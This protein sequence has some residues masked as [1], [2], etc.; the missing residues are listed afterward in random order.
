MFPYKL[1]Y[2]KNNHLLI[3]VEKKEYCAI[4]ELNLD[5]E[6]VLLFNLRLKL[7]LKKLKSRWIRPYIINQVTPHVVM[8]LTEN[9]GQSV[10]INGQR[11]KHYFG[12]TTK[13]VVKTQVLQL[14]VLWTQHQG[15]KPMEEDWETDE[16]FGNFTTNEGKTELRDECLAARINQKHYGW[17]QV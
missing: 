10:L 14:K 6:L 7:F 16:E 9:E 8:K 2:G 13:E 15:R 17:Y 5:P 12:G 1:V 3:E 11:V 4:K